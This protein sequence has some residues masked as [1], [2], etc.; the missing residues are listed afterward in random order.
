LEKKELSGMPQ[1][2][3]AKKWNAESAAPWGQF[4]SLMDLSPMLQQAIARLRELIQLPD[5]WDGY[6]SPRVTQVAQQRAMELL[7]EM[8]SYAIPSMRIDAVPGGGLQFDWR[9]GRREIELEVLPDGNVEYL[10]SE[11]A[12]SHEGSV[13]DETVVQQLLQWLMEC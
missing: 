8:R 5:D 6:G 12:N 7:S 1:L 11:G 2:Q 13:L 9:I 4:I 3:R 10:A